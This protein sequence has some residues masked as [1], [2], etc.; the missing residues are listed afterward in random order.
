MV[1][2]PLFSADPSARLV[3]SVVRENEKEVDGGLERE[4]R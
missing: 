1:M 4:G 3:A 2:W